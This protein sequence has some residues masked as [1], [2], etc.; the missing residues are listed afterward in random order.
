MEF[1]AAALVD[2]LDR[3]AAVPKLRSRNACLHAKFLNGFDRRIEKNALSETEFS[4]LKRS[5]AV[6][7]V[8]SDNNLWRGI[9]DSRQGNNSRGRRCMVLVLLSTMTY[10]PL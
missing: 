1:S 3:S 4:L 10:L 9:V 7:Q 6:G 5:T 8:S 2:N